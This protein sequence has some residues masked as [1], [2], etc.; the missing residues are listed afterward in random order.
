MADTTTI[1]AIPR[2]APGLPPAPP[3][4]SADAHFSDFARYGETHKPYD[5]FGQQ[6]EQPQQ[7]I[8]E[9]F[10]NQGA[11]PSQPAAVTTAADYSAFYGA[12]QSRNPYYY[13]S[14]GQPQEPAATQHRI[15]SGFGTTGAEAQPQ[16]PA[17]QPPTRYSHVEAPNSGQNTPNP[18]LPAQVQSGQPSQ[19][20]PQGQGA[21]GA[22]NYGYPYYSNPHY[23]SA[24]MNQMTGQQH[25]Y[26]RNRPMFDDARRYEDSHYVPHG[27]Q[28]GYGNQY[29]PY[30]KGGM[31]AQPQHG[32]TYDHS[33]SPANAGAFNQAIPGRDAAY[34]RTGSTQPSEAQQTAGNT[35][36]GGIPDVF[37]RTQSGFGHNQPMGSQQPVNTDESSN[38]KGFEAP[39]AG[40]PSPSVSHVNRPGS[41]TSNVPTQPTA[42]QAGLPPVPAAQQA[43]HQAF[44]G[45]PHLNPQYGGLGGLGAHHQAASQTHHQGTGYG[46]YAAGF[47]T[48][49]Y[50]NTGRGG[51]WGGNYGH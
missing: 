35:A 16:I 5:P 30:A 50:G 4:T 47:G 28:F 22:Y 45:Y 38:A 26:G 3:T 2:P 41:A 44:G 7:Q 31:Y 49:Y 34:G 43:N 42:G 40:G 13:G 29:A 33:S 15:A 51:G 9:P 12:D 21:H 11:I 37:G 36:F 39:K 19:H 18:T 46:N 14:Y 32:F 1:P 20:M 25:Q 27:S 23:P 10:S 24:Y 48:N 8:Q 17:S 6:V